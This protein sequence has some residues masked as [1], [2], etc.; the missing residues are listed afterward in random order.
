MR[1]R[2]YNVDM[3]CDAIVSTQWINCDCCKNTAEVTGVP[4][5]TAAEEFYKK[6]WR[7]P[8]SL[9]FCPSCT[10]KYLKQQPIKKKK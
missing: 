4:D 10:K 3:L 5:Y 9:T 6:G 8:A 7:I 1:S 2:Q